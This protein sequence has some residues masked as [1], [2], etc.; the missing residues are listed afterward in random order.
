VD[1]GVV[2]QVVLVRVRAANPLALV[3]RSFIPFRLRL[4]LS[5]G[6]GT[7]R[8]STC[9]C[10]KGRQTAGCTI[11]AM[12]DETRLGLAVKN[13]LR[14]SELQS[15]GKDLFEV[16]LDSTLQEGVLKDVPVFGTVVGLIRAAGSVRD[17]F[18]I[19]KMHRFLSSL[20]T[21][22]DQER[23]DM[24]NRLDGDA[25]FRGRVGEGVIEIIDRLEATRKPEMLA[26]IFGAFAVGR[27]S[28]LELHRLIYAVER[29]PVHEID[30]VREYLASTPLARDT[31]NQESLQ[32]LIAAGLAFDGGGW[33]EVRT[34]NRTTDLFVE[35]GLDQ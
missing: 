21:L 23:K 27:I 19:H 35:F 24:V 16:A 30:S 3:E 33:T 6:S 22:S 10:G 31:M 28:P 15:A 5:D 20:S 34:A 29:I 7:S 8:R 13:S 26:K 11:T 32:A 17:A 1:S 12:K 25:V 14:S 4:T 9:S 2:G 18:L